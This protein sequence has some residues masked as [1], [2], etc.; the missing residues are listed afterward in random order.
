M[1]TKK[2]KNVG[3]AVVKTRNIYTNLFQWFR[4]QLGMNLVAYEIMIEQAVEE[5]FEKIETKYPG[6]YNVHIVTTT[7]TNDAAEV[8]AYGLWEVEEDD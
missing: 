3:V 2:T 1:T 4:N 7:I 5:A 6:V 8:I